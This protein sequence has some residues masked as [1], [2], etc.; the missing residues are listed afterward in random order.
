MSGE[1]RKRRGVRRRGSTADIPSRRLISDSRRERRDPGRRPRDEEPEEPDDEDEDDGPDDDD[2]PDEDA[3]RS[4][5]P[6]RS[7]TSRLPRQSGRA[8]DPRGQTR[9]RRRGETTRMRRVR[10][11][12]RRTGERRGSGERRGTGERRTPGE[13]RAPG[14][15]RGTGERR[16]TGTDR[17]VAGRRKTGS[18]KIVGQTPGPATTDSERLEELQ[19]DLNVATEIQANLLPKKIPKLPG[20]EFSAY[21]RPS[22]DVGGD[23]YDFVEIDDTRLGVVI[24]D[25]SG[26]GVSGSMVMT[27]FRSVLRMH[28]QQHVRPADA[29]IH[30]NKQVTEDIKRGMFVTCFYIVLNHASGSVRV[31]SAGHN[32]MVYWRAQKGK[33][34][35]INPRGIAIGFDKGPVFEKSLQEQRFS[36]EPGDRIVVYTDGIVEAMDAERTEFGDDRMLDVI[37]EYGAE[38]SGRLINHLVE[39]VELFQGDAPQADD[40]TILTFRRLGDDE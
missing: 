2:G 5:A 27:M 31:C 3:S 40:M 19:K 36:L 21:Y 30:T 10:A 37:R 34:H 29:L 9:A 26:K 25:V 32:P 35:M 11:S 28:A 1:S 12:D 8:P 23:Y 15:R 38:S 7:V 4:E 17:R 14:E 13:R 20:Y 22:K 33:C 24:A 18:Y 16:T 39:Q 6:R